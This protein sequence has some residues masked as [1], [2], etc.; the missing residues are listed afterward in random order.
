MEIC[1]CT[2]MDAMYM[3][4]HVCYKHACN[5]DNWNVCIHHICIHAYV[6]ADYIHASMRMCLQTTYMETTYMETTYMHPCVCACRQHTCI[7]DT[8]R[9]HTCIHAHVRA[10][11]IHADMHR[12][13]LQISM[14][15]NFE[16]S[17]FFA[18]FMCMA[19]TAL[20]EHTHTQ[21]CANTF[22]HTGGTHTLR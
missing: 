21:T 8:W 6:P 20:S 19:H 9:Q 11:N 2:C 18:L 3:H 5:G 7:H 22:I 13:L 1:I 10:Y 14:Q 17:I 15:K 12:C 4:L 16:Q